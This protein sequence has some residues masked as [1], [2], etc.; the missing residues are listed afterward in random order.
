[1][2]AI[3]LQG[4]YP[5]FQVREKLRDLGLLVGSG[6]SADDDYVRIPE[7]RWALQ[8]H[9]EGRVTIVIGD[10]E[11]EAAWAVIHNVFPNAIE[12]QAAEPAP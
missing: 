4:P 12:L 5:G 3:R 10:D 2:I 6:K 7:G 11:L 1:M 9:G 8:D